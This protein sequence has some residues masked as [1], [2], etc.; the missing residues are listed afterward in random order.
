MSSSCTKNFVVNDKP[1]IVLGQKYTPIQRAGVYV[2][3]GT[4]AYP[5]TVLMDDPRQGRGRR[6]DR[7]DDPRGTGRR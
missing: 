4:A 2:P 3:G 6:A 7:H 5:S 1:G